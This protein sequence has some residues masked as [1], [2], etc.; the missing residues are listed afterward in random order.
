MRQLINHHTKKQAQSFCGIAA[1]G[2]LVNSDAPV[3]QA[4]ML[5]FPQELWYQSFIPRSDIHQPFVRARVRK[6]IILPV[7]K[8]R[9]PHLT[10]DIDS[11]SFLR[12]KKTVQVLITEF[13][14]SPSQHSP[15]F[16]FKEVFGQNEFHPVQDY[17]PEIEAIV[18]QAN[19]WLSEANLDI[20][21]RNPFSSSKEPIEK[22]EGIDMGSLASALDLEKPT[23]HKEPQ[24]L[25][26]EATIPSDMVEE[27][28]TT[29]PTKKKKKKKKKKVSPPP[30]ASEL[31]EEIPAPLLEMQ[32]T[33][34][35]ASHKKGKKRRKKKSADEEMVDASLSMDYS[36]FM[37]ENDFEELFGK[38]GAL[39]VRDLPLE[40]Y[41]FLK[42]LFLEM[43][44]FQCQHFFNP[45]VKR[46]RIRKENV[47][48]EIERFSTRCKIKKGK[49]SWTEACQK[50]EWYKQECEEV[51]IPE[52]S[53]S[54][55]QHVIPPGM[56]DK[57]QEPV[58]KFL[59]HIALKA[60]TTT[61]QIRLRELKAT[62]D[63][64]LGI[65]ALVYL[66]TTSPHLIESNGFE[67][68]LRNYGEEF[69]I[70]WD[71]GAPEELLLCIGEPREF[72][73]SELSDAFV[74]YEQLWDE[75]GKPLESA[76]G[77]SF[78][79]VDYYFHS[80]GQTKREMHTLSSEN[81]GKLEALAESFRKEQE[82]FQETK[83][84]NP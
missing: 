32:A 26:S 70:L 80:S 27:V 41:Q 28:D 21:V 4:K 63:Y 40:K 12:K 71:D 9:Y 10:L 67:R 8:Q 18:V 45:I 57:I 15:R 22:P 50:W 20:K 61:T 83:R 53:E 77:K 76:R 62:D 34:T 82:Y 64:D 35:E 73:M 49:A 59:F 5:E 25:L 56:L 7:R 24:L 3:V 44:V 52:Y 55:L 74:K 36:Q 58:D 1:Q 78:Q 65:L 38:L 54:I 47:E 23:L 84:A 75:I 6:S 17:G 16:Y 31:P 51:I 68:L 30:S 11:T 39:T 29:N 37:V 48:R 66:Q 69:R 14:Y 60:V 33:A 42:R 19:R 79:L 72:S 2:K 81:L 46:R 43:E 13:H